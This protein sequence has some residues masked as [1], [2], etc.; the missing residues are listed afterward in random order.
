MKVGILTITNGAN[1]GNRLQNYAVQTVIERLGL[2]A[3]TLYNFTG[4][5]NKNKYIIKK[6]A[7]RITA[8]ICGEIFKVN[9]LKTL[10][11]LREKRFQD[12]NNKYIY[13]SEYNISSNDIPSNI[14]NYYDYFITGSDQ[15]WNPEFIC[16]SEIDFLTFA[17]KEKRIAYSP[18]FG[19][20]KLPD[21]YKH[22]YGKWIKEMQAV[23]VREKAGAEIIK[24]ISGINAPVLVDPT[25]MLSKNEWLNI[26]EKPKYIKNSKFILTYFLGKLNSKDREK[27]LNIAKINNMEI[28]NLLD[29]SNRNIYLTNPSEF[30]WLINNCHLMCTDSF[31]GVVFSLIM[32]SNFIIF[33]RN[34]QGGSMNSRVENLMDIF[35][36]KDRLSSYIKDEEIFNMDFS[37]VDAIIKIEREKAI[38]YLKKAFKIC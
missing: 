36:I 5:G 16:N 15:V 14:N 10:I 28:I 26:S 3:E 1:Y 24:N 35:K 18:S 6:K 33:E 32:K 29:S 17:P 21:K 25:L 37:N 4:Q 12:F 22:D 34:S 38:N 7:K 9:N 27:I 20:S 19:I 23:S 2:K 8:T 31:H 13:Q 30:I 11:L